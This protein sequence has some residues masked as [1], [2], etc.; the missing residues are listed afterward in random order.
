MDTIEYNH[1]DT[2]EDNTLDTISDNPVNT[3]AGI[4]TEHDGNKRKVPKKEKLFQCDHCQE[5]FAYEVNYK[6]HQR[7]HF[8]EKPFACKDTGCGEKFATRSILKFH[9]ANKNKKFKCDVCGFAFGVLSGLKVH[10]LTH[11]ADKPFKCEICPKQF[12][13]HANL[14]KHIGLY[15][16]LP[17]ENHREIEEKKL[18]KKQF[19]CEI[20]GMRLSR[21]KNVRLHKIS[22]HSDERPFSCN[23]CNKSFVTVGSLNSH[24]KM[25]HKAFRMNKTMIVLNQVERKYE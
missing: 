7:M 12:I 21:K 10:K 9:R 2:I 6:K 13:Q 17:D 11:L 23:Q 16:S 18:E 4:V 1:V 24:N 15:A 22:V 25:Y 8:D 14:I 19:P 20:C 3:I 5:R